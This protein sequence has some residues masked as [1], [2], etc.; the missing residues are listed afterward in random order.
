MRA[1]VIIATAAL[2]IGCSK[3]NEA[4]E[5]TPEAADKKATAPTP[6]AAEPPPAS[7]T[8]PAA[9]KS[10][11]AALP[12]GEVANPKN[13]VTEEKIA[14]GR[15]LYYDTRFSKNH[16]LSCNSCHDLA[17][18]GVDAEATSPG[19][20]KQRGDRNSPTVYNAAGHIAQFWDGRE[21]DVEAQAKGPVLNP[22]EMAMP[23]EGR[24]LETIKS[25]PEYVAAFQKAFPDD[26]EPVT[27]DNFGKAIGAFERRLLTPG[28]FDA[29][30]KGD[31][32]ALTDAEKKGLNLF[33]STGCTTCH[34]GAYLGGHMYQ[35][36]GLVKPWPNEKDI[37][38]AKVT[39]ND[40]EKFFFKVPSL[41]NIA[42]TGP[43]FHDGS[44]ASLP[45]AVKMMAE[46]Q[47]GKQLGDED[48]QAIVTFLEAL[49]GELPTDYI[50]KPELPASTDQTPK[51][52][53]N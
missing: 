28:R 17:R 13:P 33:V 27:Y 30:L 1:L 23:D 12:A 51:P 52:D 38:R 24:V 40:A 19:H 34:T 16:D 48:T 15:M 4:G 45:E 5:K 29:F 2:A 26:A 20:K 46:Y 43:Y 41:R 36:A 21:P 10:M 6:K 31:D 49:T 9:T 8:V 7:A 22:V 50:A 47:L 53:P 37:G 32:D 14:L 18:W 25:M 11:F 42:K 39:G 35:K 44:V 3:P